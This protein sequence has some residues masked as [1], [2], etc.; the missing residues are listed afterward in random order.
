MDST[1]IPSVHEWLLGQGDRD[2]LVGSLARIVVSSSSEIREPGFDAWLAIQEDGLILKSAIEDARAQHAKCVHELQSTGHSESFPIWFRALSDVKQA[3]SWAKHKAQP[4]K[5]PETYLH[6]LHKQLRKDVESVSLLYLDTNHWI[7]LMNVILGRSKPADSAYVAV[8]AKLRELRVQKK[9]IC[10]L[11]FPLFH[12]L[13]KQTDPKTRRQMAALIDEMSAG[14]CIQPPNQMERLELKRQFLKALLGPTAPDMSE[15][16][17]VKV[18]AVVGEWLAQP[19]SGA[20]PKADVRAMQ[21]VM[22][23]A[24]WET[25]LAALAEFMSEPAPDLLEELAKA[26]VKDAED[27]RARG[28]SFERV[29]MEQKD[30][31]F[32]QLVASEADKIWKEIEQQFPTQCAAFKARGSSAQ[33]PD[34]SILASVQIKAAAFASFIVSTQTKKILI[35]DVTDA[36][37]VSL[38]L[39]HCDAACVDRG[40]AHRL[41]SPPLQF[42]KV[43]RARVFSTPEELLN[44]MSLL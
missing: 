18:S 14:V 7:R 20:L 33:G 43:Y 31:Y 12:E 6:E 40:M 25:P 26:Y 24:M 38:A 21:K 4:D 22:I 1:K 5:T 36:V 8:L 37:H 41:T 17:W 23:D 42:D 19:T 27:Y 30:I 3:A 16:V 11:S 29:L 39:P 10:P 9:L 35:N 34:P 28:V 15:W 44:W 2:D 32:Q 13:L